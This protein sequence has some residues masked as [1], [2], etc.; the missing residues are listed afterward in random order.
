MEGDLRRHLFTVS[1]KIRAFWLP[2]IPPPLLRR[3]SC[4][5]LYAHSLTSSPCV[6]NPLEPLPSPLFED[7]CTRLYP[8]PSITYSHPSPSLFKIKT[9]WMNGA[10]IRP[11]IEMKLLNAI[12]DVFGYIPLILSSW[13][14][15]QI[16]D[17]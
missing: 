10:H 3:N 17:S 5:W 1:W 2:H 13:N 11:T 6:V 9:L 4:T 15:I 14:S 12:S 16:I 8:H 7:F